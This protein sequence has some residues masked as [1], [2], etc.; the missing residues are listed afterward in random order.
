MDNLVK[1]T[2]V[3]HM[4]DCPATCGR[5]IALY[6]RQTHAMACGAEVFQTLGVCSGARAQSWQWQL[7][8]R[9]W[10]KPCFPGCLINRVCVCFRSAG[11]WIQLCSTDSESLCITEAWPT[12]TNSCPLYVTICVSI[13]TV[14]PIRLVIERCSSEDL[15]GRRHTAVS[16][17]THNNI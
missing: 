13:S 15:P 16:V 3:A 17:V 5:A 11:L 4:A 6:S 7:D 14:H 1:N 8:K 9:D 12:F 10:P 2:D